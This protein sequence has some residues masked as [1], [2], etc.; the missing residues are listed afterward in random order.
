[1]DIKLPAFE[2]SFRAVGFYI[3]VLPKLTIRVIKVFMSPKFVV[4]VVN[5]KSYL[6]F[7]NNN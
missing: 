3:L 7:N 5:A 6:D 2:F 1:M 4:R